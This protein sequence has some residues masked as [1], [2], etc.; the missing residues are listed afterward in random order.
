MN[1][2]DT[3]RSGWSAAVASVIATSHAPRSGWSDSRTQNTGTSSAFATSTAGQSR[4]TPTATTR[5]G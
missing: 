2:A 5:P 3:T 1:P 4:S